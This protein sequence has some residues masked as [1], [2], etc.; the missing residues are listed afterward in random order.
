MALRSFVTSLLRRDG[1][2]LALV[3]F[4]AVAAGGCEEKNLGRPCDLLADGGAF[5]TT[6][7]TQALECPTRICVQPGNHPGKMADTVALCSAECSSNS[8]CEDG[9]S[10]ST[11]GTDKRC[12]NGFTCAV[13]SEVGE[14]CCKKVCLC[15][16]FLVVPDG[17]V[18]PVPVSCS[19]PANTTCKNVR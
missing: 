19:N 5:K 10:R 4:L 8:D 14:M 9:E 1:S 13:A 11:R 7:N 18:L 17:G 2:A 3:A 6:F 16:D 12:E 15:K